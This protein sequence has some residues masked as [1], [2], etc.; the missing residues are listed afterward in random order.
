LH[1]TC[2]HGEL[3]V[4][5]KPIFDLRR[6]SERV[7]RLYPVLLDKYGN[8]IDG[9]HRLTT[10]ENWP[11]IKL[12][13]IKTEE[14]RLIARLISNV[15]RRAVPAR[16]KREMLKKLG[17]IYFSEGVKPGKIAYKIAE[18]TGM[19]YR[20]VMKYLPNN[21]K[22]RPGLGG[23]SKALKFDKCKEKTQKSKVACLATD[24]IELLADPQEKILAVKNYANTDFVN[25]ILQKQFYIRLEG[26][27]EKLGTA[28][29]V[30]IGNALRLALKKLE[31]IAKQN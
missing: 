1:F 28:P 3:D 9:Q 29:D 6:S 13:H 2:V 4:S 31:G 21:L 19:S 18:E 25:V 12:G 23:P 16:E 20:W 15:C 8:V 7:G 26:V 24:E 22:E 11:K 27:A 5:Q 10:D 30:I 14:E 17:E